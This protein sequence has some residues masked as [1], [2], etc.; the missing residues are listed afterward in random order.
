MANVIGPDPSLL[1]TPE[2]DTFEKELEIA[3]EVTQNIP[4]SFPLLKQLSDFKVIKVTGSNAIKFTDR[5]GKDIIDSEITD[6]IIH[7]INY[8]KRQILESIL[9][10]ELEREVIPGITLNELVEEGLLKNV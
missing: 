1:P 9:K 4:E 5:Y 7:W 2:P 6:E 3:I 10:R 8:N